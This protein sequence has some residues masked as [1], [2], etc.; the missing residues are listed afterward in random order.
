MSE[1]NNVTTTFAEALLNAFNIVN[2]SEN[3]KTVR[4]NYVLVN[5]ESLPPNDNY[6]LALCRSLSVVRGNQFHEAIWN[7]VVE[8]IA[9]TSKRKYVDD[10]RRSSAMNRIF[11]NKLAKAG[12]EIRARR[13]W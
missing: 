12:F 1:E 2:Y 8:T 6:C 13:A 9:E 4:K 5:P 11:N 7:A 3:I 10:S